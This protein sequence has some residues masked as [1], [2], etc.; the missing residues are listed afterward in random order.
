M[1]KKRYIINRYKRIGQYFTEDLGNDIGLDMVLI[2]GGTL[3][4][5]I[6]CDST[7]TTFHKC[8]DDCS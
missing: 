2:P 7:V 1:T 5:T 4:S 6:P 3:L 8:Y